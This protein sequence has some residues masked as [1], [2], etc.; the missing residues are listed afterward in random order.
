LDLFVGH[1]R[2]VTERDYGKVARASGRRLRKERP[3]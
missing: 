1:L 3:K 2:A